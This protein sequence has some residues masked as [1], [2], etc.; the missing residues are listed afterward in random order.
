VRLRR[1]R[2]IRTANVPY[3]HLFVKGAAGNQGQYDCGADICRNGG[4]DYL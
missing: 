2:F 4:G 1:C 3:F